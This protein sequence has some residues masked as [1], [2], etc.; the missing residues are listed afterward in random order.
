LD[1]VRSLRPTFAV[2]SALFV[3]AVP[4]QVGAA[5]GGAS[6]GGA[7]AP[8]PATAPLN[9]G[10]PGPDGGTAAPSGIAGSRTPGQAAE[11]PATG[12]PAPTSPA[13]TTTTTATLLPNGKARWPKDAPTAVKHA[14]RAGNL[15]Q[16]KPYRFGGGHQRWDDDAYD[17]SGAVSYALRGGGLVTTPLASSDLM[18]WGLAGAGTWI[19][20]YANP[21]HTFVVIAGLRLDTGSPGDRGP[22]WRT[23]PRPTTAYVA[24]HPTAL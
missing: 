4:G 14:I 17:C 2:V 11:T 13:P 23:A 15:L 10:A 18:T 12:T 20:V 7:H 24:R 19:T 16:G 3:L 6:A 8:N 5:S 21:N 1:V 22:R 9:G